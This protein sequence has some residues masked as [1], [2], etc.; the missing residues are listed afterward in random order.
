MARETYPEI[1]AM[2]NEIDRL[3]ALLKEQREFTKELLREKA[4]YKERIQAP[5]KAQL[6][7]LNAEVRRCHKQI[8]AIKNIIYNN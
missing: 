4:T 8:A 6:I 3:S 7:A 2:R 5:Y 1:T